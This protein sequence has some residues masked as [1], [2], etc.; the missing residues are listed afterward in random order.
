M[1]NFFFALIPFLLFAGLAQAEQFTLTRDDGKIFTCTDQPFPTQN[2]VQVTQCKC[3]QYDNTDLGVVLYEGKGTSLADQCK[4]L[5]NYNTKLL[6]CANTQQVSGAEMACDCI[7]YDGTA[8]GQV[9]S[10]VGSLDQ[11][12]VQCRKLSNYNVKLNN[13]HPL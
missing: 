12:M 3:L 8:L 7:Q 4:A 10:P 1:R 9:L 2:L 6:N 13:C 11:L 5:S